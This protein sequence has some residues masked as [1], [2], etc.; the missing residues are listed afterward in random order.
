MPRIFQIGH[1][2][3]QDRLEALIERRLQPDADVASMDRRIWDLFGEVWAVVFTDMVGFSQR[4]ADYGII[5]FLQTIYE[6]QRLLV[7]VIDE[8]DGLLLK[9]EGDSLL[10]LFRRPTRA[11]EC[12]QQMMRVLETH[13]LTD[14]KSVV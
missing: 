11:L 14:R 5:H 9:T 4:S 2:A 8:H 6:S 1:H 3:A 12:A 7:P 13:N 10:I